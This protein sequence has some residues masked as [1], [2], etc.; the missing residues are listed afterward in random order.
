[1]DDLI[2]Q[3]P[4]DDESTSK[5][6]AADNTQPEPKKDRRRKAGQIYDEKDCLRGLTQLVI[7]TA[8]KLVRSNE[9]NAIKG[10]YSVILQH[11]QRTK[12]TR[13]ASQIDDTD[14]LAM[15]RTNPEMLNMLEP[16]LTDE[17]LQMI[18]GQCTDDEQAEDRADEQA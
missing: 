8:M 2:R 5:P 11:H 12:S 7:L 18:R 15:L 13:A 1:M 14:V 10:I 16:L 17:Q 6:P 3:K 9:A 4:D